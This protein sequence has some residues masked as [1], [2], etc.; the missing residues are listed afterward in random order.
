MRRSHR[1]GLEEFVIL[2][3]IDEE[4]ELLSIE[5]EDKL[6]VSYR[7]DQVTKTDPVGMLRPSNPNLFVAR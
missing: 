2:L 5:E 1:G 6:R 7:R 3:R 4:N